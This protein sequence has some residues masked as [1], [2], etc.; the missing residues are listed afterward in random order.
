MPRN[1]W[2]YATRRWKDLREAKLA[3]Q[4]YCETCGKSYQLQAHHV[5][6]ISDRQRQDRDEKAAYPPLDK[7]QIMCITCHALITRGSDFSSPDPFTD[8]WDKFIETKR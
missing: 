7:L 5:D 8:E 2:P 4:P 6:P 3:Q 1:N